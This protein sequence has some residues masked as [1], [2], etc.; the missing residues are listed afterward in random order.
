MPP[1]AVLPSCQLVIPV[2][3]DSIWAL[4]LTV[5]LVTRL[6]CGTCDDIRMYDVDSGA[7]VFSP[8]TGHQDW[9]SSLL[10]SHDGIKLFSGADD[11]TIRRWS[12]DTGE[13]IGH[14]W[15]G[16]TDDINSL[17]LSPDGSI[18][19]SASDG[20]TVRFWDTTTGSPI[21]QPLRHEECVHTVCFSPSGEF[22]GISKMGR[23]DI[24]CGGYL[25]WTV[26]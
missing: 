17:S 18:L 9:V 6:A 19:A 21:G 5:G 16:H 10:W 4:V 11:K 15:P 25:S 22:V 24:Y 1:T 13:P 7:L 2:H 23:K 12:S 26:G 20:K 8:L 14:P 3:D